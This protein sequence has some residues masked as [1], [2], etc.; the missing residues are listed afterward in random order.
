MS[1]GQK[2]CGLLD[3]GWGWEPDPPDSATDLVYGSGNDVL[4]VCLQNIPP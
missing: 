3:T 1:R 2:Q 4:A